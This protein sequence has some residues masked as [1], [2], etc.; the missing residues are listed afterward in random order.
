MALSKTVTTPQGFEAT[1]AYIT[2]VNIRL[3]GKNSMEFQTRAA[4]EKEFPS[5]SDTTY[6]AAF[7]LDGPNPIKQAY[8]YL[9]TL[10]EFADAVDC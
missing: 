5:F 4:K 6:S 2:C 3:Y 1:N 8:E 10:P 7:N 9:K